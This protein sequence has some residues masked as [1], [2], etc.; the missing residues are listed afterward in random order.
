MNSGPFRASLPGGRLHL[1]HGP[2]DLI[3]KAEGK[4]AAIANAYRLAGE[5]FEKVLTE[6]VSELALLRQASDPGRKPLSPVA[7][8]MWQ[9]TTLSPGTFITPMAAVAG[10]VADEILHVMTRDTA[11]LNK[12]FVNNGGDIALWKN[13]KESFSI[14]LAIIPVPTNNQHRRAIT[15]HIGGNDQIGGVATSGRHGR[16]L[17]LGIADSVTVLAKNAAIAD[18]TATLIANAVNIKSNKVKRLPASEVELESD[19]GEQLVTVD[20]EQLD[21]NE[22]DMALRKGMQETQ[23]F[24]DRGLLE[25]V[26]IFL[27]GSYVSIPEEPASAIEFSMENLPALSAAQ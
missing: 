12:V 11:D 5:R 8:R 9:A 10:S 25:S 7:Q 23:E 14:E 21:D 4:S 16:S 3:I 27:Q 19:L 20:V 1:Q 6:L 2:I 15:L 13:A 17:S 22:R 26:F 24:L 18:T